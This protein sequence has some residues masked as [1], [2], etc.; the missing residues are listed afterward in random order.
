MKYLQSVKAINNYRL[1]CIFDNEVQKIASIAQY[2]HTEAFKPLQDINIF[3]MVENKQYYVSWL[4]ETI[5][6]SA[7]TL[8]YIGEDVAATAS[9][10]G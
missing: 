6:L 5:D 7:D 9:I 3:S 4:N 1:H 2:L 8:W 10:V